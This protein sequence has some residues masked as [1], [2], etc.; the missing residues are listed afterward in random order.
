MQIR[1][2]TVSDMPAV[3]ALVFELAVYEREPEAV[4]TTPGEYLRDFLAG[5]FECIVAEENGNV[6]GMMLF[7]EAYSTWKGRMLY[8][9]DFVVNEAWRGKGVGQLLF[10]RFLE[11]GKRRNC[12]LVK[13]QVLDWNEPAVHFYEKNDCI[14]EKGW[15]NVKA[16]LRNDE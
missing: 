8:L 12:R 4:K 13:W 5:R 6:V 14:I 15:W 2:A 11:E 3:H 7:F 1:P 10:N 16:V 9:D